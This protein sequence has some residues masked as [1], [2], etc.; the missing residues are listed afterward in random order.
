MDGRDRVAWNLR[1]LRSAKGLSQEDLAFDAKVDR[2][3][4]SGIEKGGFNPSV[5]VLESLTRALGADIADLFAL[6]APN[7]PPPRPLTPGRKP[8]S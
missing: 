3:Y 6:P 4:I 2:S 8:N 5:D 7:D 1:K